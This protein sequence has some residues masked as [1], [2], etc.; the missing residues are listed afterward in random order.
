MYLHPRKTKPLL[1]KVLIRP[2]ATY[3]SETWVIA[4]KDEEAHGPLERGVFRS[5]FGQYKRLV[6]RGE[7]ITLNYINYMIK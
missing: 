7:Y 5:F 4:K 1:Y 2:L 6:N 3:A